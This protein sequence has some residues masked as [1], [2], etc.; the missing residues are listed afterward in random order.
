MEIDAEEAA[1]KAESARKRQADI[2]SGAVQMNG[3]ELFK[4][5][6]WASELK[7]HEEEGINQIQISPKFPKLKN[8]NSAPCL[9]LL[10][11]AVARA[12]AVHTLPWNP[13]VTAALGRDATAWRRLEWGPPGP[14]R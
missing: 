10:I 12:T 6:P 2:A 4:H 7:Q 1:R 9:P 5:E 11:H 13:T 3:R 8:P 14:R